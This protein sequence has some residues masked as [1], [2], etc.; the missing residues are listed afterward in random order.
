RQ[1]LALGQTEL[2][3]NL[4]WFRINMNLANPLVQRNVDQLFGHAKWRNERFMSLR[5]EERERAFLDF[6]RAEV[7]A[8]FSIPF[9]FPFSPEDRM[10][11]GANRTKF[12]LVHFSNHPKAALLMK[13]VMHGAGAQ[14]RALRQPKAGE[15]VQL[16][17]FEQKADEPDL[18][19]LRDDLLRHF[20]RRRVAFDDIQTETIEWPFI[21]ADYRQV[22]KSLE[23]NGVVTVQRVTS[24]TKR[25]LSGRDVVIFP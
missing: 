7:G 20:G 21:E 22:I 4:M 6:F 18:S 17:L 2:L 11:G 19:V 1:I 15:P 13:S 8:K 25:G 12:Y 23:E 24:K 16:S 3:V 9:R 5:G 10:A 14:L